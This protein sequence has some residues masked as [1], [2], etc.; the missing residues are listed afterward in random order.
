MN[1]PIWKMR[2]WINNAIDA[3]ITYNLYIYLKYLLILV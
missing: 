3:N 2:E 1:K